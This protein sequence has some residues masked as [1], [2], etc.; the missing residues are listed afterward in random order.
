LNEIAA[1]FSERKTNIE[2]ANIRSLKNRTAIFDLVVDVADLGDLDSL[3]RIV[4]KIPDV[5]AVQRVGPA[6]S[7]SAPANPN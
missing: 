6:E 2:S 5:L 7:N 4:Q 3:I 1:I